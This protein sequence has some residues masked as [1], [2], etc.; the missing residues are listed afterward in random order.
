MMGPMTLNVA[1]AGAGGWGRNLVRVFA[2]LE[3]CSLRAVCDLNQK[4]LD[5]HRSAL[6]G[7]V[8]TQN[9]DEVLRDRSIDALVVAVD[10]PAHHAVAKAALEAGKH[11][12]VEKPLTVDVE[13]AQ[14][15]TALAARVERQL[16]VGHLLIYHPAMALVKQLCDGGELGD[17]HY[18]YSQ[19]LNLGIIRSNE[20]AWWSLA[21]HDI[22][23]ALWLF[24]QSPS[25]V[26]ATG[27]SYL[28]TDKGIEDVVF[29]QLGFPDGRMAQI[30]VSWLDPNKM[31][32]L[33]IVGSKRMLVFDDTVADEKVRLY[34]KGAAPRPG[35]TSYEAG[36]AVRTGDIRIPNIAMKE[37]LALECAEFR[38]CILE[39][40]PPRTPGQAGLDVVRVLDAGARSLAQGGN[41]VELGRSAKA[42][43]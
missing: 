37:P 9:L 21:P 12:L 43:P 24:G 6:P 1:V 18:L 40:R 19:R 36:V 20:N 31:R 33:T 11:V 32:K 5:G 38:D 42:A 8:L 39:K 22:A 3:G 29:A 17:V 13:H 10:A 16:M 41:R 30:H 34:D 25:S 28:Q 7:V 26:V 23:L 4:V 2:S 15:L 27:A 35:Y 14:E